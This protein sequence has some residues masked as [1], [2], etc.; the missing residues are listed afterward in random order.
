MVSDIARALANTQ[1]PP[2]NEA[3]AAGRRDALSSRQAAPK[4]ATVARF[5]AVT[6]RARRDCGV[7][8]LPAH[9]APGGGP[10]QGGSPRRAGGAGLL[11]RRGRRAHRRGHRGDAVRLRRHLDA[12]GPQRAAP[13]PA[14]RRVRRGC[15][16]QGAPRH[17]RGPLRH[18]VRGRERRGAR[19]GARHQGYHAPAGNAGHGNHVL[20]RGR[21]RL[22]AG[23]GHQHRPHRVARARAGGACP[24][25]AMHGR[26]GGG[27]S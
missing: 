7:P 4:A 11:S 3:G 24:A 27:G 25:A 10:G 2:E 9:A 15:R 23:V 20:A 17:R 16:A 6:Q 14:H 18:R 19:R 21:N 8:V 26:R 1:W 12:G 13:R 22:R 5:E